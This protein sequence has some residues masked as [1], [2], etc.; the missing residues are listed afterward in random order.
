[1]DY[2]ELI[3]KAEKIPLLAM[4][5]RILKDILK[6]EEE[7]VVPLT[8]RYDSKRKLTISSDRPVTVENIVDLEAL[9]KTAPRIFTIYDVCVTFNCTKH[10]RTMN[11]D[12]FVYF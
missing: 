5:L 11:E 12:G 4:Y 3:D 9:T 6:P 8:L 2:L 1:M 10:Y 7:I